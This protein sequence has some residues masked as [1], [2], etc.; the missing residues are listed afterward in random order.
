MDQYVFFYVYVFLR[1]KNMRF[2][3]IKRKVYKKA[4]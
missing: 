1:N 3:E 2:A 4:K